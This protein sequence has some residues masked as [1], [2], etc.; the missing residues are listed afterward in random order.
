M[1]LMLQNNV[2]FI[3]DNPFIMHVSLIEIA[4]R[5]RLSGVTYSK[6]W[7]NLQQYI[8][9]ITSEAIFRQETSKFLKI[10]E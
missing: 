3:Q 8:R 2:L 6:T 10:I 7:N 1:Q 4:L 5:A 9:P